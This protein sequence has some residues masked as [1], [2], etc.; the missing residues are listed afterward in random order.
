MKKNP[1]FRSDDFV[2]YSLI[3][4]Y[5]FHK[6]IQNIDYEINVKIAN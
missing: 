5:Y 2:N 4:Y 3:F 6:Q 1:S